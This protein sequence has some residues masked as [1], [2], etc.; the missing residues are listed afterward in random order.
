MFKWLRRERAKPARQE[1]TERTVATPA[2]P[3]S[4]AQSSGILDASS[5]SLPDLAVDAGFYS[6]L[7]GVHS[8]V[9]HDLNALES[10]VSR[11]LDQIV[12]SGV[13]RSTLVPRVPAVM[14]RLMQSLRSESASGA[15][16]A[17]Q[18]GRDATLVAEVLR[19]ANSPYYRTGRE[20]NSLE[21][22]VFMLGRNGLRQ[23]VANAA[24][25]PLL[26]VQTG[27]F[28]RHGGPVVWAQAEK[29]AI[30]GRCLAKAEGLDQFE[31]YLAGLVQN[32]GVIVVIQQLDA[33][34]DSREA[35]RSY[36]FRDIFAAKSRVL[37]VMIAAEWEFPGGVL[38]AIKEQSSAG[39]PD[40]MSPLGRVLFAADKLSKL[41]VLVDE[42][43]SEDE[44]ERLQ[45]G[46]HGQFRERCLRC[47]AEL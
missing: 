40:D 11:E 31:A 12:S 15:E 14:P 27:H 38:R 33:A 10:R 5:P 24:M 9:E 29:C 21:Q 34:F 26:N 28:S 43:R 23:L 20:I 47:Y 22:A 35:A 41:R 37:S 17:E 18:V 2:T 19:L 25:K 13:S 6:L 8:L 1:R 42:G 36:R 32:I 39:Q 30:A 7:L 16:I 44:V 46:A 45:C 3:A 4:S